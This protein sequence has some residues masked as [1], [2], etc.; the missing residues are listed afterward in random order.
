LEHLL[1][2]GLSVVFYDGTIAVFDFKYGGSVNVHAVL[3]KGAVGRCHLKQRYFAAEG[4]V[5]ESGTLS[6]SHCQKHV[7]ISATRTRARG[8]CKACNHYICDA[9]N[10]DLFLT[11]QCQSMR[12]RLDL[13]REEAALPV[14]R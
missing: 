5:F 8:H 14:E 13:A 3:C 2:L 12:K 1:A 7:A 10:A 4:K 9:C 11:G 6:C